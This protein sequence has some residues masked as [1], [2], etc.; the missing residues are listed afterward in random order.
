MPLCPH[1][2]PESA[3][4]ADAAPIGEPWTAACRADYRA[5]SKRER[6][7]L[8]YMRVHALTV[9]AYAAQHPGDPSDASACE[10]GTHL[11][12]LYAQLM[13]GASQRELKQ[14]RH[15]A[16]ET[17]E[18]RW[19][20]PPEAPARLGPRHA[21]GAETP[22]AH[23]QRVHAWALSVWRAWYPHSDQVMSWARRILGQG[24]VSAR[25]TQSN[26]GWYAGACNAVH[27]TLG[28]ADKL[29]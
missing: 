21:L 26:V 7:D 20:T 9:D 13:L 24:R 10:L 27:P 8:R 1:C 5:L 18:F 17:I 11:V 28:Q 22:E 12:S 14:I 3:A 15:Q 2:N 16:A 23:G 6:A 29:E 25:P 19:L 4:E